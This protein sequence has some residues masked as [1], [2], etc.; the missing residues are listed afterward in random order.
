M[1]RIVQCL[2]GGPG[3]HCIAGIAYEPET[4]AKDLPA[5]LTPETA[6]DA[7]RGVIEGMIGKK[8]MNPWCHICGSREWVYEDVPSRFKTVE[9]ATPELRRLYL[10]N[11][12]TRSIIDAAKVKARQN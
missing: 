2:C 6:A 12:R 11:M 5:P 3:R 9:E 10:E 8:A 7:F 4:E 1:V